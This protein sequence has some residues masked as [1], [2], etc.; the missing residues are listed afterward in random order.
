MEQSIKEL[1]IVNYDDRYQ[2]EFRELNL[3]W[4]DSY[5]LTESHD[6]EVLDD[7]ESMILN[8]GGF[9]WLALIDG[10]VIGS[11]A[12]V[13]EHDDIGELAKMSVAPGYRGR[14]IAGK[15]IETCIAKAREM[16]M[17]KLI[18]FSNHQLETAIKL[19]RKYGFQ[20]VKV[21]DSPFETADVKMELIL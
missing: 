8:K 9:L 12:L 4:L 17:N 14:G 13:P 6:L 20:F 15:L 11:I 21:E 19:Y 7:P 10:K 16:K 18:L 2:K 1:E 5:G 3:A